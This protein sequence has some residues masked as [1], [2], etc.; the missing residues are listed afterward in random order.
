[1]GERAFMEMSQEGFQ[2]MSFRGFMGSNM[3]TIA[4]TVEK[5]ERICLSLRSLV[6]YLSLPLSLSLHG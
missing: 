4:L 3:E 2:L 6:W 5:N 1:M